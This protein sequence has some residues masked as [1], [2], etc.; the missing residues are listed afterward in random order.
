M[1]VTLVAVG[2]VQ[3]SVNQV[4]DVV[5]MRYSLVTAV[6]AVNMAGLMTAAVVA[7]TPTRVGIGDLD[8]VLV[9]VVLVGAVQMPVMQVADGVAVLDG[10]VAATGPMGV[11]RVFMNIVCHVRDLLESVVVR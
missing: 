11:F 10:G 9:V 8:D 7:C 4:V 5:A 6:R 1:V 3:V 2:M